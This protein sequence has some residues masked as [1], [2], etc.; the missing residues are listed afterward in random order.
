[1]QLTSIEQTIWYLNLAA[2]AVLFFRL[3]AQRILAV[4]PFVFAF[5][6][7]ATMGQLW[8]LASIRNAKLYLLAYILGQTVKLPLMILAVLELCQLAIATRTLSYAFSMAIPVSILNLLLD[9]GVKANCDPILFGFLKAER[10]V[11]LILGMVIGVVLFRSPLRA[12]RN[13]VIWLG[14]FMIYALS[15][16]AGLLLTNLEPH[17]TRGLSVGMLTVSLA[18]LMGW[19]VL[20]NAKGETE[21]VTLRR[22]V[23]NGEVGLS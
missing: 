23:E 2:S 14:G 21:T 16:W 5:L 1:M 18:C 15:R 8:A 4:H 12:R 19:T 9:A 3:Y 7:A 10:T 11:N 17:Y 13:V 20:L 22:Q 6:V